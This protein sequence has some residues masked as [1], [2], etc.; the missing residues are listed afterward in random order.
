MKKEIVKQAFIKTIPVMAGYLVLGV[1]FGV[2][3]AKIGYGPLYAILMSVTIYAG[4]M[5]YV[6]ISLIDSAASLISVAI[7]TL[8]V[9][10]RHLFYGLS[11]LE[12]YQN[13]KRKPYLIFGMTDETYSLLCQEESKEEDYYFY[14]TIFNHCYWIIGCLTGNLI[15]T[16]IPFNSAGIEFSMTAL[17]VAIVVEQWLTTKDHLPAILGFVSAIVCLILFG[18]EHFLIPAMLAIMVLLIVIRKGGNENE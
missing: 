9:N 8:L 4:S 12:K 3:L 6:A 14:I 7:T 10:G 5:Q 1:G 11:M 15:G 17:F 2:L 13:I 18:P 16:L